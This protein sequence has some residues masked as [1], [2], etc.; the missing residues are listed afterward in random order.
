MLLVVLLVCCAAERVLYRAFNQFGAADDALQGSIADWRYA[1]LNNTKQYQRQS[2]LWIGTDGSLY[3][4]S[5]R[6]AL[7]HD[8]STDDSENYMS[9][10]TLFPSEILANNE[11][12]VAQLNRLQACMSYLHNASYTIAF[13]VRIQSDYYSYKNIAGP[14]VNALLLLDDFVEELDA[15]A[16]G[17]STGVDSAYVETIEMDHPVISYYET[18]VLADPPELCQSPVFGGTCNYDMI[19]DTGNIPLAPRELWTDW[20]HVE[21]SVY[22]IEENLVNISANL[23]ADTVTHENYEYTGFYQLSLTRTELLNP[24]GIGLG[25]LLSQEVIFKN[26]E[27]RSSA[28]DDWVIPPIP[29]DQETTVSSAEQTT[30]TKSTTG[31]TELSMTPSQSKTT[32]SLFTTILDT[33]KNAANISSVGGNEFVIAAGVIVA[34]MVCLSIGLAIRM[35]SMEVRMAKLRESEESTDRSGQRNPAQM[36]GKPLS[37]NGSRTIY[38]TFKRDEDDDD[39]M[40]SVPLDSSADEISDTEIIYAPPRQNRFLVRQ[41][42]PGQDYRTVNVRKNRKRTAYGQTSLAKNEPVTDSTYDTVPDV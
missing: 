9:L 24:V 30:E 3:V 22:M 25:A 1:H 39:V 15:V 13:D 29:T 7:A 37:D 11:R 42:V 38:T 18:K 23:V 4:K 17:L 12:E 26:L 10:T 21:F 14:R 20:F 36:E 5:S 35:R 33:A 19:S 16:M 27:I 8:M 40:I 28:V 32:T 41:P 31:S 2:P 6:Y 34:A